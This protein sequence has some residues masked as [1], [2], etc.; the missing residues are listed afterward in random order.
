VLSVR[1]PVVPWVTRHCDFVSRQLAVKKFR[2]TK[3]LFLLVS[4][5]LVPAADTVVN[6]LQKLDRDGDRQL[7]REEVPKSIRKFKFDLADRNKDGFLDTRELKRLL[8]KLNEKKQT[9]TAKPSEPVVPKAGKMRV[10]RDIVYQER[11]KAAKGQNK[12]DIYLPRD[13]TGFPVLFWIHGGGLH[14]GDKSKIAEVAARFVAEEIGV[15]SANYRLYPEAIYPT[16]IEDVA[17][18]FAWV[19][20]NIVNHGGDPRKLFVTGGSAGGHLAALITLNEA[21]LKKHGLTGRAIRGAIP[22]SGLMD[23][24][25]VGAARRVGVWGEKDSTHRIASPLHHARK[26]APPLLLLHAEH[27]TP[28]RRRQNQMMFD[29]LKKTGHPDVAIHEL[30]DRTHNSIRPN[31]V[32]QDDPGARHILKFVR[33]LC[34]TQ[35]NRGG[36]KQRPWLRHTIDSADKVA[37]KLGADGVRLADFNGDGLLD[38]TTGWEQGGAIVVYQNPGP[39]KAKLAWPSVTVGIVRSPEDAVFADLDGDGNLDVVSSCEGREQ[40]M[41]VHWAPAK[42]ADYLKSSAWATEVIAAT[43]QKQSWMFAEPAQID[44]RTGIELFVSSKGTNGSIGWLKLPTDRQQARKVSQW[45]FIKLRDAGWVMTLK[46]MDMDGDGDSD[47]LFSDRKGKKRGV[48][49]LENPGREK[50]SSRGEW[51]EHVLGGREHEVMFLSVGD[52][53]HDGVWDIVCPTRNTEILLFERN[54]NEWQV[55]STPNPFGVAHGKA[56]AIG[57]IDKDGRND[58]FHVTNTGRNR[59]LPGATWISHRPDKPWSAKWNVTDVSGS[60]GVKFDLVELVDLDGDGDLDAI[61]CEEVDN[62]GV[63]W[64][65]NPLYKS[66]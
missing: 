22:I 57:D 18:A 61:T 6:R 14:S 15:V 12:L 50:V 43:K 49:W 37:G 25:R 33:R 63:F 64:F 46:A 1:V 39:A 42:Q 53:N 38:I 52:L 34:V 48:S 11:D 66:E 59:E 56:V 51:K 8:D 47:L 26:D 31:L 28:D 20:R 13:K 65:E 32:N 58:L 19:H 55:H 41:Y 45:Q 29:A 54:G 36:E 5:T 40:S 7:S 21:F 35:V 16:Q 9:T 17:D 3:Y 10:V 60:V 4:S 30:K 2:F 27:D 23:V 62:L 44:G 24:S